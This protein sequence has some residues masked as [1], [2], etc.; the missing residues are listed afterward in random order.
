MTIALCFVALAGSGATLRWLAADGWPGGHRGTLAVN[1]V[2]AFALGLL[3]GWTGP[4][5]TVVG[6]GGL[7]SLTTFSTFAADT[8]NLADG[9]GGVAAVR[10]VAVTLVLGVAAAWLGLSIAG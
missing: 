3:G 5:L 6:A 7:G 1:V 2:G 8:T 9:S 4:A 10:H